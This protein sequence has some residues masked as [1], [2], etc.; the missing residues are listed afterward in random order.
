[1]NEISCNIVIKGNEREKKRDDRA[2]HFMKKGMTQ[3]VF[4]RLFLLNFVHVCMCV[5][6]LCSTKKLE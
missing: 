5:S 4:F 2:F 3:F 6:F 1:M